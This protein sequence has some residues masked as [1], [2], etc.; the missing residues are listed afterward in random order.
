MHATVLLQLTA[1]DCI[2]VLCTTLC[3]ALLGCRAGCVLYCRAQCWGAGCVIFNLLWCSVFVFVF[4]NVFVFVFAN[5]FVD[6]FANVFVFVF[7]NVFVDVF[8]NVF[9]F[10]MYFHVYLHCISAAVLG[11]L[12]A[13]CIIYWWCS[14]F[15]VV[16]KWS[17]D[18]IV[19]HPSDHSTSLSTSSLPPSSS[20][21]TSSL[22]TPPLVSSSSAL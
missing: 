15:F 9:V 16:D 14:C 18:G 10:A 12:A 19:H 8:T 7:A 17:R 2:S 22:S 20:M 3:F 13:W 5:V 21:S 4:A 6:V 11:L 1:M